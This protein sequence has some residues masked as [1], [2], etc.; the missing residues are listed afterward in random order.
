[1]EIKNKKNILNAKIRDFIV[2][3]IIQLV[4]SM[5][6]LIADSYALTI[7]DVKVNDITKNSAMIEWK[8]DSDA[9]ST[10]KYGKTKAISSV[11]KQK[12]F[13]SEHSVEL[14]GLSA[15]SDYFFAVESSDSSGARIVENNSDTLYTFKTI[16]APQ[17]ELQPSAD[18][19]GPPPIEFTV[20]ENYNRRAIDISGSTR[21][22]SSVSIFVN[23]MN[24]PKKSLSGNEVGSSGKFSF[25]QIQL[26]SSNTIKI[27]ATDK[28]SNKN[29]KTFEIKVDTEQPAIVLS[30]ISNL[31]SRPNFT[32]SG[33]A[34]ELVT[35]KVFVASSAEASSS[36]PK[37]T[38]LNS[39][40]IGQ[41]SIEIKWDESKDKDF[42]HYIVYRNSVAI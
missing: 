37:I 9:N 31:L 17:S 16:S 42:S 41:N 39:T 40:N 32:I 23:D 24:A 35:A 25:T 2:I 19:T 6:F 38:G 36:P 29:E 33:T 13:V 1:M 34:S 22:F 11:Q 14:A 8:T 7:S 4:A 18:E 20:P 12:D 5:P 27:A 10:V 21:P 30:N 26:E 3:F 15:N 28:N